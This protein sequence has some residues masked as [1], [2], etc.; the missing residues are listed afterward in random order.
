[1]TPT[2]STHAL[3]VRQLGWANLVDFWRELAAWSGRAGRFEE[4]DGLV[5]HATATSFPVTCNG[6]A[7]LNP[8]VSAEQVIDTADA[9][10]DALGR[11]YTLQVEDPTGRDADLVAVAEQR[12][13]LELSRSPA[14]VRSAPF[15]PLVVPDGVRLGWVGVD[16]SVD[17]FIG[18][19]DESYQSLGMPAG[20]IVE[21]C[22]SPA[23]MIATHVRSVVAHVDER[24][25]AVAQTQ[26]GHGMAGVYYVGV[27]P[28][29]RG[30]GLAEL[31][32]HAVTQ[33]AFE[34]GAPLVVLQ[35]TP[36]GEPVYRRMGFEQF[37]T[38]RGLVRFV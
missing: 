38:Y 17:D 23:R 25:V 12:G 1:M 10:F 22:S 3:D 20:V 31:V 30:R 21:M 14:M 18:V 16:A 32:T 6:V 36:V 11:G 28:D 19:A 8:E 26:T 33:V 2:D 37:Q 15:E 24:P 35:A 5:L 7:R 34:L 29:A 9:W 13:L 4:R 27:L